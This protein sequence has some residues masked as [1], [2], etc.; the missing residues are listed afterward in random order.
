MNHQ[1]DTS[2]FT[3]RGA[4]A[5]P[6]A[7]Y[8]ADADN[9]RIEKL[10]TRVTLV[11]VLIPCLLVV[12]LV[13][14]YLDIKHRVINTQTS[15]SMG[16]QN[17]SKDLESRFSNLSLKQAKMEEQLTETSN[18][19]ETATAA[20]QINLKKATTEFKRMTDDKADRS[21]LAAI[22]HKTEASVAALQKDMA[23]L[24]TA[25]SKF[26]EELA[27]QILLMADGLKKDQGRLA[28]IEKKAQ[29]LDL[30]KLSKESMELTLG[31]ERLGLQEMVKDRIREVEKKLAA[32]SKQIDSLN[33]RLNAQAQKASRSSSAGAAPVPSPKP[34]LPPDPN[35]GS[36]SIVEQTIN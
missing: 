9:L 17:L 16:V 29:R 6:D 34:P 8:M 5:E 12:V 23:D 10:S 2:R 4:Q 26:D 30:E 31:L 15:G 36:S 27:A 28:E 3:I 19:L 24:N 14:A 1:D 18:A 35:P 20:L 33:Q 7:M 25:F 32:F 11:A 21:A 13:I 22:T